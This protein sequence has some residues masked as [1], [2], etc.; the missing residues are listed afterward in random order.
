MLFGSRDLDVVSVYRS[1][2]INSRQYSLSRSVQNCV[3][4]DLSASSSMMTSNLL[5]AALN[6]ETKLSRPRKRPNMG[7]LIFAMMWLRTT[8]LSLL[9][10]ANA[11]NEELY[12]SW[13]SGASLGIGS[14]R[15]EQL[16]LTSPAPPLD[17]KHTIHAI[18]NT[19]PDSV[20]SSTRLRKSSERKK[21]HN[22]ASH[23]L[24][25]ADAM[26]VV[27]GPQEASALLVCCAW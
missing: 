6:A 19:Y 24:A 22:G 3:Y 5:P 20:T 17:H 27:Y 2:C 7:N 13:L 26:D 23:V 12:A 16:R 4:F 14:R 18:T 9:S 11:S 25:S 10:Q 15:K 1:W 8:K 21:T